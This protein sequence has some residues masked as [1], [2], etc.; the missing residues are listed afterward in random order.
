[1]LVFEIQH[2][3]E[4]VRYWDVGPYD[5]PYRQWHG[6]FRNKEGDLFEAPYVTR[7]ARTLPQQL[8]RDIYEVRVDFY[9]AAVL[10]DTLREIRNMFRGVRYRG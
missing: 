3:N 5:T 4:T 6:W 7:D 8:A 9:A 1:M 10:R 2:P